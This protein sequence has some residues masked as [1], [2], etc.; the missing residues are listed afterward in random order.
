MNIHNVFWKYKNLTYQ[1]IIDIDPGYVDYVISSGI[2]YDLSSELRKLRK[3]EFQGPVTTRVKLFLSKYFDRMEDYKKELKLDKLSYYDL[4]FGDEFISFLFFLRS[5]DPALTGIWF[6]YLFRYILDYPNFDDHR[7]IKLEH[8][9]CEEDK[10]YVDLINKKSIKERN[11]LEMEIAV[12]SQMSEQF[13]NVN[14]DEFDDQ[15][16]KSTDDINNDNDDL[17]SDD[18]GGELSLDERID[19]DE[20]YKPIFKR[21]FLFAFNKNMEKERLTPVEIFD[22]CLAHPIWFANSVKKAPLLR[23]KLKF[24]NPKFDLELEKFKTVWTSLNTNPA[25]NYEDYFEGDGDI[26]FEDEIVEIKLVNRQ[27]DNFIIFQLLTYAAMSPKN[28]K[29]INSLQPLSNRIYQ[30]D[31]T[32]ISREER[33]IWLDRLNTGEF[34]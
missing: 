17:S 9:Y 19:L 15:K 29:C 16:T 1:Q 20:E 24:Y 10:G 22:L 4:E 27:P 30:W 34:G 13:Q 28:I 11:V 12:E 7:M 3:Y 2:S 26:E 8:D 31:I 18:D 14:I 21:N 6:D 32:H 25:Y 5:T 33:K 23:E